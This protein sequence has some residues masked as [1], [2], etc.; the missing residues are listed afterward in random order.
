MT[1]AENA[2]AAIWDMAEGLLPRGDLRSTEDSLLTH[3][4]ILGESEEQPEAAWDE[5]AVGWLVNSGVASPTDES[6][7]DWVTNIGS[8]ALTGAAT[9]LAGGPIGALV[10]GLAGAGM[11]AI[12]TAMQPASQSRQGA[13]AQPPSAQHPAAPPSQAPPPPPV[14]LPPRARPFTA[15][16]PSTPVPSQGVVPVA[17]V[18]PVSRDSTAAVMAQILALLPQVIAALEQ[19]AGRRVEPAGQRVGAAEEIEEVEPWVDRPE[20]ETAVE[21]VIS[22]LGEDLLVGEDLSQTIPA[23]DESD[24]DSSPWWPTMAA[25]TTEEAP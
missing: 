11:G 13:P 9:G 12:Q 7:V 24:N 25:A 10:G 20:P 1:A 2:P 19:S 8:G 22:P 17:V 6:W 18:A 16:S 15:Q 14:P 4:G 21:T 3:V 5:D 23:N